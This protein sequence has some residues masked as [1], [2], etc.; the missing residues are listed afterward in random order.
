MERVKKDKWLPGI[1]GESGKDRKRTEECQGSDTAR[2]LE[3]DSFPLLGNG[4]SLTHSSL[5]P[6]SPHYTPA[7]RPILGCHGCPC[8]PIRTSGC[9]ALA[10][11]RVLALSCSAQDGGRGE[12]EEDP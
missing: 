9:L 8:S 3:E 10:H 5:P 1:S 7:L 11:M 4:L 6:Q 12:A 2:P